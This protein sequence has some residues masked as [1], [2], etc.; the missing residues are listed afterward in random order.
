MES[1]IKLKEEMNNLQKELEESQNEKASIF[2]P[3]YEIED[4]YKDFL[5]GCL[6]KNIHSSTMNLRITVLEEE[7]KSLRILEEEK[8]KIL[9]EIIN[10]KDRIRLNSERQQKIEE[11]IKNTSPVLERRRNYVLE[12]IEEKEKIENNISEIEKRIGELNTFSI[13][14]DW[15]LAICNAINEVVND[16]H[17]KRD[18]QTGLLGK[19]LSDEDLV[20][21][22]EVLSNKKQ[23][24]EE[25]KK[26]NIIVANETDENKIDIEKEKAI[27]IE[28]QP[29]I[30]N[31]PKTEDANK[32]IETKKEENTEEQISIVS[33]MKNWFIE[34]VVKA[35]KTRIALGITSILNNH[36]DEDEEEYINEEKIENE[37]KNDLILDS[38]EVIFKS[39]SLIIKTKDLI[40]SACIYK[41]VPL[42]Q[43]EV[44][45]IAKAAKKIKEKK[46]EI[47]LNNEYSEE[48]IMKLEKLNQDLENYIE[49]IRN[50]L[51]DLGISLD[52]TITRDLN[53]KKRIK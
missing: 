22:M 47:I 50:R 23:V 34:Q 36:D 43:E 38:N 25:V 10:I 49:N 44:N 12:K 42:K 7:V 37:I 24:K 1:Y 53:T 14:R 15:E 19:I 2:K 18:Y 31:K 28:E 16:Y 41:T 8:E 33:K 5:E 11:E 20:N 40:D 29:V 46:D 52:D 4:K 35:K 13:E 21:D 39:N 26:D 9:N 32:E 17:E 48:Q 27:T 51:G 45:Y 3:L 6:P 30:D